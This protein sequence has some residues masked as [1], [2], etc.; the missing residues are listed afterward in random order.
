MKKLMLTLLAALTFSVQAQA[1]TPPD[2]VVKGT[3][4]KLQQLIRENHVKY[5]ADQP[6]FYK[7]VDEVVLPHFDVRYIGQL[8]LARHWR[9]A[10][11]EQRS[12]FQEAFKNMLI[13]TYANA[14][15]EY[16]DSVE[17]EWAPL[18][19]ADDATDATV[20]STLLRKN[21]P[22]IPVGFV[23]RKLDSGWKIYDI[24]IENISLIANFRGQFNSEIRKSGLDDVI[25]RME[26]GAFAP[27]ARG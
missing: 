17:A 27:G 6:M 20:N 2:Q 3:T 23:M 9:D 25:Q 18:R 24:T 26:N 15:L 10:S 4:A 11:E 21:G 7:V 13:R 8:V 1:V 22:P 5:K 12:R 14:L 16:H 19:L